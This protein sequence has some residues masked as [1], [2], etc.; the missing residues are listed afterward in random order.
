MAPPRTRALLELFERLRLQRNYAAEL[1]LLVRRARL[2]TPSVADKVASLARS[3][4]DAAL[5]TFISAFQREHFELDEAVCGD[6]FELWAEA[7]TECVPLLLRGTDRCNG[8]EPQGSRPGYA[9][10]WALVQD[11]FNSDE[12]SQLVAEVAETFGVA[13]SDRLEAIEPPAHE[14][15][16]RRLTRS[17]YTGLVSFSRW[18]LGEVS[19]PVLF[20]PQH[21]ADELVL[22]WTSRGVAHA[23][24]LVHEADDFQAPM[25]ALARWLEHAPAQHGPLLVDA[26]LGQKEARAWR[27][28]AIRPCGACGFPPTARTWEDATSR[29]LLPDASIHAGAHSRPADTRPEEDSDDIDD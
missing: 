8:I 25:L 23:A 19:N 5:E 20:Y 3:N 28:Q 17:P 10:Q 18:A 15:L 11:V 7:A 29:H 4:P 13:L 27:P 22:P 12:R 9:L 16:C 21:H 1:R 2:F 24:R 6:G 26:V 14:V